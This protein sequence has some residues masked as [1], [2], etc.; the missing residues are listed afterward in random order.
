MTSGRQGHDNW[1]EKNS[2]YVQKKFFFLN[3]EQFKREG[4]LGGKSGFNSKFIQWVLGKCIITESNTWCRIAR[5]SSV[6][7]CKGKITFSSPDI[8]KIHNWNYWSQLNLDEY[9]IFILCVCA[10]A[11]VKPC[12]KTAVHCVVFPLHFDSAVCGR[13]PRLL[14]LVRAF[15]LFSVF[16]RFTYF[17]HYLKLLCCNI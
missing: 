1:S 10:C 6:I 3:V 17:S 11:R 2:F 7:M 8:I 15:F 13:F 12:T 4:T 9:E 14:K 5:F 16:H